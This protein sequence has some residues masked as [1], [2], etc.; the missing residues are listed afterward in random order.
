MK[1]KIITGTKIDVIMSPI[2]KIKRMNPHG[3]IWS[4]AAKV[5]KTWGISQ[6]VKFPYYRI[7]KWK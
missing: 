2:G 1:V 5:L 6:D 3:I 4:S 7:S